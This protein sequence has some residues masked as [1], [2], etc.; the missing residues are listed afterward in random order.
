MALVKII[1]LES[2]QLYS[3]YI[4]ICTN[5]FEDFVIIFFVGKD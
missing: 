2:F 5:M 1:V 4:H 3:T